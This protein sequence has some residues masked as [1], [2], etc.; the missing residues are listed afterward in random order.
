MADYNPNKIQASWSRTMADL[1]ATFSRWGVRE[2]D[3][4][5]MR[6]LDKRWH[7]PADPATVTVKYVRR[8]ETVELS[9]AK[10][11]Y[12]HQNLRILYMALE[13]MRLNELRGLDEVLR[14]AYLQ[15][16]APQTKR[17]PWEVLG[18]RPDADPETVDAVYRSLAKRKHP[19]A[20][21]SVEAFKELQEAYEAVKH[22]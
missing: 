13:A 19:D 16:A 8:G 1:E 10:H 21:G 12:Y 14:D 4:R 3:C 5:P 17:D 2:W 9:M 18:L 11:P 7:Y 15:L 20:G 6:E 22:G